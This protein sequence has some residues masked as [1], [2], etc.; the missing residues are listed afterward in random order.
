M[1]AKELQKLITEHKRL[2]RIRQDTI[3]YGETAK[4]E[5]EAFKSSFDIENEQDRRKFGD[6]QG[7]ISL[8]EIHMGRVTSALED[9]ESKLRDATRAFVDECSKEASRTYDSELTK[10]A[11]AFRSHCKDED[12]AQRLAA[13]ASRPRQALAAAS[14]LSFFVSNDRP[15]V[16]AAAAVLD[17]WAKFQSSY[18][19][20][21]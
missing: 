9:C 21:A 1:N 6:I 13:Q 18:Q 11:Q 16:E 4:T 15:A 19:S 3:K 10:T 5:L 17:S 7:R 14:T 8:V 2:E 12:E 20:A